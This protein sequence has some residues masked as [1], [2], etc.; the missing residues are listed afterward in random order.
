MD[1]TQFNSLKKYMKHLNAFDW[2]ALV[3]VIIGGVNWGLIG[4]FNLDLVSTLFGVMTLF[5][6]VVYV[7]VGISAIYT[8]VILSTKAQ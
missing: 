4:L 5:T 1:P 7:L 8:L 3:L 2:V 6:R